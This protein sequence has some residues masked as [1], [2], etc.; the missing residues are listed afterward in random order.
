[1]VL[2]FGFGFG[3]WIQHTG[4]GNKCHLSSYESHFVD[5]KYNWDGVA[6]SRVV[7]PS[8]RLRDYSKSPTTPGAGACAGP[9]AVGN[10]ITVSPPKRSTH[11]FTIW[12][13][14]YSKRHSENMTESPTSL[15]GHGNE[16]LS[17]KNP[18]GKPALVESANELLA[19]LDI[20]STDLPSY[21][22]DHSLAFPKK[23]R[24]KRVLWLSGLVID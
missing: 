23:V 18:P 3:F 16:N 2:D 15:S 11:T 9:S 4:T 17:L 24:I 6:Q 7:A 10:V 8:Y 22:R 21:A 19:K 13:S 5:V 12:L 1:L 14:Y 20:A